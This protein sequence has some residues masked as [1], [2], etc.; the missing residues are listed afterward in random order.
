MCDAIRAKPLSTSRAVSTPGNE[1]P[2][3]TNVIAT[4]GRMP[5]TTRPR[6]EN[7]RH[8]RDRRQHPPDEAVDH[9]QRRDVDHD[10]MGAGFTT[11]FGQVVLQCSW[12]PDPANRSGSTPTG[13]RRSCSI[14]IALH[15]DRSRVAAHDVEPGL[16]QLVAAAR[17]PASPSSGCH[18]T[19][20]P[21]PPSVCAI[22]GRMP[23]MMHSAPISRAATTVFNRCWATCVSTAAT[24]VMSMM[25]W[26][27]PGVH[28]RLQ[29][30]LHHDL[31]AGPVEG[32][33]QRHS[34]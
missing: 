17:R 19:R 28:Q 16:T 21:M 7:P 4:A 22:C 2:S 15:Y 31:R 9:L 24:P 8:R 18:R 34:Q 6:V 20:Y 23:E 32:P 5:T 30:R 10:A 12:R 25:A 27:L 26:A 1:R 11:R 14:G 33:D 3:S 29:Q 13:C